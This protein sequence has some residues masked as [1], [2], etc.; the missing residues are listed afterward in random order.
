M[1]LE[2]QVQSLQVQMEQLR[3][4]VE[5]LV[6]KSDPEKPLG[7]YVAERLREWLDLTKDS[8]AKL[9]FGSAYQTGGSAGYGII[10]STDYESWLGVPDSYVTKLARPLTDPGCLA[11]IRTL[12][13]FRSKTRKELQEAAG[14]SG[15]DLEKLL[16]MLAEGRYIEWT[17]KQLVDQDRVVSQDIFTVGQR[18][19]LLIFLDRAVQLK[20]DEEEDREKKKAD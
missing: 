10:T 1:T 16:V 13:D 2:E 18:S 14:V 17:A 8:D 15:E 4:K 7:Q 5:G 9:I 6:E 19:L 11:I 3:Q 12:L 20:K